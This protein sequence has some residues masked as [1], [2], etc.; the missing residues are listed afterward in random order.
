MDFR[1]L[2][3]SIASVAEKV[4][5]AIVPGAGAAIEAGKAV[6]GLIDRAKETFGDQV[7]ASLLAKREELMTRVRAHAESTADRLEGGG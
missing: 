7:P 5:P 1:G 3:S 6:V 2:I 4:L